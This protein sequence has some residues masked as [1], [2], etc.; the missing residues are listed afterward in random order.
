ML[1]TGSRRGCLF[2]TL[3]KCTKLRS[4]LHNFLLSV[5]K[6]SGVL[7]DEILLYALSFSGNEACITLE[8]LWTFLKQFQ[9]VLETYGLAL[10][11]TV[12][13]PCQGNETTLFP[14]RMWDGNSLLGG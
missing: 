6:L 1:K 13:L 7:T 5:Q 12:A 2:E 3:L 11:N 4:D 10:E 14:V 9:E 8:C